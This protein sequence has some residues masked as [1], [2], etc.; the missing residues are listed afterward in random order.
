MGHLVGEMGVHMQGVVGASIVGVHAWGAMS[1]FG[2][3]TVCLGIMGMGCRGWM[4]L[5]SRQGA[6]LGL[7]KAFVGQKLLTLG[8]G[9]INLSVSITQLNHHSS[10]TVMTGV[11]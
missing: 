2:R 9:L 3:V 6:G 1:C 8:M 10:H 5:S 7:A 4:G 11:G